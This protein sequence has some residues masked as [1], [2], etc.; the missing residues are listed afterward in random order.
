MTEARGERAGRPPS[1]SARAVE[2]IAL[3]LFGEQG[4]EDTTVEQIAERAGV[5]SR[6]FF[7]YFDSKASVL[8]HQFDQEV[9][10]LRSAFDAVDDEL[11]LMEAIRVVVVG[12]NRY[13]AQDVAELRARMHLIGSVPALAASA[14]SRYEPWEE[15]VSEYAGRRRGESADALV[16][17]AI[18]RTTLAA[19]R[20]AFDRWVAV[21]DADLTVY[22]DA[23]LRA[24]ATGFV[25][26]PH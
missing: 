25:D 5:S 16:P 20:A 22:L 14:A 7:R 8:W 23:A 15:A 12:V 17:L 2:L 6:T 26:E 13:R 3:E 4:F 11:P 24:L 19:C 9:A 18:G 10:T 21:G 1:T